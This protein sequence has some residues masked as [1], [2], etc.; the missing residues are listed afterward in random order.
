MVSGW[1]PGC[2]RKPGVPGVAQPQTSSDTPLIEFGEMA[3][4]LLRDRLPDSPTTLRAFETR[5]GKEE[6]G[7]FTRRLLFVVV[8]WGLSKNLLTS[9]AYCIVLQSTGSVYVAEWN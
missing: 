8:A 3:E 4:S 6:Q 2:D 1:D 7:H 9:A 5:Q